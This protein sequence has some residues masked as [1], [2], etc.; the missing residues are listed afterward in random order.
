LNVFLHIHL[1]LKVKE[2]QF[3]TKKRHGKIVLNIMKQHQEDATSGAE[4][5]SVLLQNTLDKP[6]VDVARDRVKVYVSTG[7]KD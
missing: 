3:D 7:N 1:S 5:T 6:R 4:M 2:T